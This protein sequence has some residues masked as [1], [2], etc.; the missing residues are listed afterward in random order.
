MQGLAQESAKNLQNVGFF[1]SIVA[2]YE[3]TDNGFILTAEGEQIGF[4]EFGAGAYSD[5]QH[6]LREEAPFPVFSGSYSD[7]V[8][9]GTWH[10]WVAVKGNPEETYPYNRVPLRPLYQTSVWIRDNAT[11][12]I[13]WYMDGNND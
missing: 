7:T 12:I 5:E 10:W 3:L 8:G 6:P 13:R 4:I 1:N 11:R 2:T 9:A